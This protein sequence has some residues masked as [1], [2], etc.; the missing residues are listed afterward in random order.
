MPKIT[1]FLVFMNKTQI[2]LFALARAR[3]S[4]LMQSTIA[5]KK[6]AEAEIK[7]GV[8]PRLLNVALKQGVLKGKI[9][10]VKGS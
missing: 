7:K 6:Y 1:I 4:S 9:I 3:R 5:I 2:L 8:A 10:Q